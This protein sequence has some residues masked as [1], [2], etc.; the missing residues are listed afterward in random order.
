[1]YVTECMWMCLVHSEAKEQKNVYYKSLKGE[2]VARA[3]QTSNSS[4]VFREKSLQVKFRV[5]HTH[6]QGVWLCSDGLVVR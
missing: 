2:G 4:L 6:L 5:S 1:M 3:L